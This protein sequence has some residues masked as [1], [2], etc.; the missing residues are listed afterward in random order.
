MSLPILELPTEIIQLILH[1]ACLSRGLQ[2]GLRLKL[3]CKLFKDLIGASIIEG[4][5]LAQKEYGFLYWRQL[6]ESLKGRPPLLCHWRVQ[7]NYGTENLW[8]AYCVQRTRVETDPGDP[9]TRL[10]QLAE[11]WCK[12]TGADI[13]TTIS[14]LCW[15]TL[16]EFHG[17]IAF[18]SMGTRTEAYQGLLVLAVHF[19]K[20]SLVK[21]LLQNHKWP[22][23]YPFGKTDLLPSPWQVA[24]EAG[25]LE[26][27][28][29]LLEAMTD[30][31][32]LPPHIRD[33][34]ESPLT[35]AFT[36][37]C[38]VHAAAHGGN[39]GVAQEVLTQLRDCTFIVAP[40]E[41]LIPVRY[42]SE[43]HKYKFATQNWE[44]HKYVCD[45]VDAAVSDYHF[46][47]LHCWLGNV[48]MVRNLLDAGADVDGSVWDK[49]VPLAVAAR[50]CHVE[51][52]ELLLEWGANPSSSEYML[53]YPLMAAAA[54]GSLAIVRMLLDHGA[55]AD[56]REC[57]TL[58]AFGTDPYNVEPIFR[59]LATLKDPSGLH[60]TRASRDSPALHQQAS[61]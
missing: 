50:A 34:A 17:G 22:F 39:I 51:V 43:D 56:L 21:T 8:H 32:G 25:N 49:Q 12:E 44:V 55:I 10:R 16:S 9:F 14:E 45:W 15:L 52:V 29:L 37:R 53:G 40:M 36:E 47:V 42:T 27:V 13:E 59:A 24:V 60:M 33:R 23:K 58:K 20:Q 41:T 38:A 57:S 54:G 18:P 61:F 1:H 19:N 7:E 30:E 35:R 28:K 4:L 31:T 48:E 6:P 3:V 26:V 2:R 46:V 11:D 5:L